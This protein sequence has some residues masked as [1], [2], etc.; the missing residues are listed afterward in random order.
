MSQKQKQY[1]Q[2]ARFTGLGFQ[3]TGTIAVMAWL[4][5]RLDL[6]IHTLPLFMILFLLAALGGN[7]YLLLKSQG[8]E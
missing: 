6:Y 4:G 7:I 3:M 2:I 8:N 5:Y 1:N